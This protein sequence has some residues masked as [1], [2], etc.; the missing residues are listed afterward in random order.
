MGILEFCKVG[1]SDTG[2]NDQVGKMRSMLNS[3]GF[4]TSL[5][6]VTDDRLDN[7]LSTHTYKHIYLLK[8][9]NLSM[10]TK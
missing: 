10:C 1:G 7:E 4:L 9:M 8:F 3:F 6:D 5:E 2:F